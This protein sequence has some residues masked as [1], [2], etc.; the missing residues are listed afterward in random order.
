MEVNAMPRYKCF[1]AVHAVQIK[2]LSSLPMAIPA[3]KSP[4]DY[5]LTDPWGAQ[6][7]L[8]ALAFEFLFSL[9]DN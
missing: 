4:D 1:K 9:V 2:Q 8:P 5:L 6:C 7:T 3:F